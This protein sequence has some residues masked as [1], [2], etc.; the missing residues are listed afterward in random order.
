MVSYEPDPTL[1]RINLLRIASQVDKIFLVDNSTKFCAN[2]F[3]TDINLP[4]LY[5]IP[6]SENQGV[7]SALNRGICAAAAYDVNFILLL[8]QDSECSPS[9]I[10]D[11]LD[12]YQ[13]LFEQNVPI[14][15]IGAR[16]IDRTT[17]QV[18][19][20][21]TFGLLGTRARQ[22]QKDC[23]VPVDFLISSGS[24]ISMDTIE[25]VG[26][27][28][29]HLFIDHVDTEWILRAKS[30]GLQAYM[31]CDAYI[32]HAI[33]E[34]RKRVWAGRWRNAPLH[35]PFRYYYVYRNYLLLSKERYIPTKWKVMEFFRLIQMLVFIIFFGDD[36]EESFK[37]IVRGIADGLAGRSGRLAT[38]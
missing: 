37:F 33:G 35:K 14:S 3:C 25:L 20:P 1:L 16:S 19:S 8:D 22:C 12:A 34:R 26:G 36:R 38:H 15:A 5:C 24:L 17:N 30:K 31:A 21:L 28:R 9:L 27:M 6:L 32:V 2:D 29:E 13:R 10:N 11:L 4:H 7:A 23:V 18:S